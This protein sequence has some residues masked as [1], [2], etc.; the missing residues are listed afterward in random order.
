MLAAE[1]VIYAVGVTW[2]AIVLQVGPG[3]AVSEGLTPFLAGDAIKAAVAAGLL[4]GAWK[5]AC[6]SQAPA[7]RRGQSVPARR[8]GTGRPPR[9][10][11][12]LR[13]WHQAAKMPSGTGAPPS[14]RS[15]PL[16]ADMADS[17]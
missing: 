8:L 10:Q 4:P 9:W 3:A 2:L 7:V 11:A 15:A 13:D 14:A 12:A 5:L 6:R 1:V 17:S 16:H